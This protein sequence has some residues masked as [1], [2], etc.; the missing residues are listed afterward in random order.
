MEAGEE[1][2]V[3]KANRPA[4]KIIPLSRQRSGCLRHRPAANSCGRDQLPPAWLRNCGSRSPRPRTTGLGD[5]QTGRWRGAGRYIR[6]IGLVPIVTKDLS[7]GVPLY[8]L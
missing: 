8:Q 7:D 5:S 3:V 1:I 4:A 2:E 6:F